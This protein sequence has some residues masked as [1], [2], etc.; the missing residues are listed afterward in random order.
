[1]ILRQLVIAASDL[2]ATVDLLRA[3]LGVEVAFEDPGVAEFGLRNA[4]LA[5]G[6]HF[7]EVVSPKT[8]DAPAARF[9]AG[10]PD[11]SGY[12]AILQVPDLD[13]QMAVA[14]RIGLRTVWQGERSD[15]DGAIR[16]RHLHPGDLGCIVS[17]D[18]AA[19][20]DAWP[21]AGPAWR[22]RR[23]RGDVVG[24]SSVTIAVRDVDAVC[25]VWSALFGLP[26]APLLVL[27]GSGEVRI[28]PAGDGP[29]G[30]VAIGLR[31]APGFPARS[32]TIGEA[33]VRIEVR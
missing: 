18:E 6:D 10:R 17:L 9:L 19:P 5:V 22:L 27:P 3:E 14:Q 15:D 26:V 8:P 16:G 7:L 21:W 1:M 12:M 4:V 29:T 31:A 24:L 11:G 13:R 25:A 2:D 33:G 28:A 30:I 32:F 20:A 23:G